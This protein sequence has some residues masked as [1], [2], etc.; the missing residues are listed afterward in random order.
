[1]KSGTD[2]EPVPGMMLKLIEEECVQYA[3]HLTEEETTSL[4]KA[5]QQKEER[6]QAALLR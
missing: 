3:D 4:I 5:K 6:R 1:M 2:D